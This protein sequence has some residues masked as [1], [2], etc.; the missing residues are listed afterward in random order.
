MMIYLNLIDEFS[1]A[2]VIFSVTEKCSI[3]MSRKACCT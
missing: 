3:Y 1:V 2:K